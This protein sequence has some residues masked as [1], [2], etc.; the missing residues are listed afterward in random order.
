MALMTWW[1]AD[2]LPALPA[3]LG[4]TARPL[5][6]DGLLAELN[7]IDRAEARARRREGH[8]PYVAALHGT[9]VA[10]GWS[11]ARN[12]AIGELGLRFALPRDERYLWDFATLPAYRGR[13]IYPRLLQAMVRG[14]RAARAWIIHAPENQASGA[15][16]ARAGFAPVGRL[17]FQANGAVVLADVRDAVRARWGAGMLGVALSD[18]HAFSCWCCPRGE[19][20]CG[21]GRHGPGRTAPC[22]CAAPAGRARRKAA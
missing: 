7:R 13:G 6:D 15:G 17:A 8:T 16:I 22:T 9:P 21:C 11:A 3:L 1:Q 12:A 5:A 14:E 18:E 19:A 2:P 20:A 4:L 10:Y